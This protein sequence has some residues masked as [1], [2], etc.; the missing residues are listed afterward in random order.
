M[1]SEN[2]SSIAFSAN[3]QVQCK[4]AAQTSNSPDDML[5][6]VSKKFAKQHSSSNGNTKILTSP[7][8]FEN[9]RLQDDSNISE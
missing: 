8:Q 1:L 9:L 5:F 2:I 4:E 6:Q 7:N 3:A